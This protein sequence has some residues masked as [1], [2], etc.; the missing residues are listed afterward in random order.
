MS[1]SR[2]NNRTRNCGCNK[3]CGCGCGCNKGC[4]KNKGTLETSFS[5]MCFDTQ[6]ELDYYNDN[7]DNPAS[8]TAVKLCTVELKFDPEK[9]C[10]LNDRQPKVKRL[11][12]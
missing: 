4:G 12:D 8:F 11:K 1:Q 5:C 7:K 9:S 3:G 10:I 2:I 6:E